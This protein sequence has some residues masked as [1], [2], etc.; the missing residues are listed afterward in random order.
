MVRIRRNIKEWAIIFGGLANQN[1]LKILGLLREK[2]SMSVTDLARELRISFK[3][4][5]RNLRILAGLNLV[6]FEGRKDRVY[7][8]LSSKL[9]N[10]IQ[11]VLSVFIDRGS[12]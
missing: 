11:T 2:K 8:S 3:N 6:E 12:Q 5:S 7:Y 1:R 4:T 9:P 10:D